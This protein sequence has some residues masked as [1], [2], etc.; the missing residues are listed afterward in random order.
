MVQGGRGAHHMRNHQPSLP[1]SPCDVEPFLIGDWSVEPTLNRLSRGGQSVQ[2]EPR[3]MHVLVCLAVRP[4]KVVSRTALLEVVWSKAVVNEEGL[5]HAVS[6]LRRV[7][8]DD[9]KS[10]RYI[11]TIHKTG[12][13]LV[14]PA[15]WQAQS[16]PR[17]AGE[18]P[19]PRVDASP[20]PRA[21]AS[22]SLWHFRNMPARTKIALAVGGLAV[23]VAVVSVMATLPRSRSAVLKT[24]VAFEAQPFTT[25]P[26]REIRPAIS[27]DGTR[28]A[29]SWEETQGEH[30]DLYVKQTNTESALR[31]TETEGDEYDAVWS[32]DG[33]SLAYVFNCEGTGGIYTIPAIGG[34]PRKIADAPL[35]AVGLDWSADG[36]LVAYSARSTYTEPSKIFICDLAAGQ[37]RALT[38]PPAGT[39]G[40]VRPVFSPDGR[41]LAF[42]RGDRSNLYDIFLVPV[43]GG[44]PERLTYSQHNVTGLDWAADGKS[45]IFASAPTPISDSRLWRVSIDDGSLTWLPTVGRHPGRP[46]VALKGKGLVYEDV[47]FSSDI[48]LV[49]ADNLSE[50]AVP[51][52]ASTQHDYGPQY[53]PGGRFIAFISTRSGSPQVWACNSDGTSPRQVT[54]LDHAYIWNPCW[55]SDE[56]YIAFSAAPDNLTGV[57]VAE[58]ETGI[59]TSLS[60]SDCHE[61][62]LGWSR[63]GRWLYCKVERDGAWWVRKVPVNGR[64]VGRG[65][66]VDLM[67]R[68]LFRLAE[69]ADGQRLIYSR[70]DTTGV[71]ACAL[72][73][74]AEV[75][76]VNQPETV[77]PCGWRYTE[78]GIYFFTLDRPPGGPGSISLRFRHSAT[79]EVTTITT[80]PNFVAVNMDVSPIGDA[81]VIDRLE[82]LGSDLAL[83]KDFK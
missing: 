49:R 14:Q 11:E 56:R 79:G 68:D 40:D 19:V 25:Y 12:Y 22:G 47:S 13:R 26:G 78:Q 51:I 62:A 8:G 16:F 54:N 80:S 69:S 67:P 66:A 43:E 29:F 36:T 82:S 27:P 71:W 64:D 57:Y 5:T 61:I 74:T 58:V 76:L 34:T 28:I 38:L 77:I 73:G 32:P 23:V 44:E 53:S 4:G 59:V 15:V 83:V 2:I 7:L 42:V 18:S 46:S 37:S 52:A 60:K 65:G 55:S 48:M 17:T 39:R 30:F 72:D 10:P 75:C 3:I 31:L 20:V 35:G 45:L 21:H 50:G 9:P 6:Q 33:T 41:R 24:P 70:Q 81:V 63:D 1:A